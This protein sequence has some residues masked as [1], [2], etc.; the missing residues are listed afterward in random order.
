[1]EYLS[2]LYEGLV[3]YDPENKLCRYLPVSKSMAE[4]FTWVC[5]MLGLQFEN[6]TPKMAPGGLGIYPLFVKDSR[7]DSCLGVVT[8]K[9]DHSVVIEDG[10]NL[11]VDCPTDSFI[12][13]NIIVH[14]HSEK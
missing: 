2:G 1:M 11:R 10:W 9:T 12:A 3:E 5:G 7:D 6:E 8:E 4:I 14:A 13:N